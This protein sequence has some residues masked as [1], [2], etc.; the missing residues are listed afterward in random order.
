MDRFCDPGE[1]H[2]VRCYPTADGFLLVGEAKDIK[3][4]EGSMNRKKN[5]FYY[6]AFIN[7]P[8]F[9]MSKVY[10]LDVNEETGEY[11]VI[12]ADTALRMLKRKER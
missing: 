3:A 2:D 8:I 5:G 6:G 7:R 9:N 10:G 11:Y 1:R 12:S 4:I